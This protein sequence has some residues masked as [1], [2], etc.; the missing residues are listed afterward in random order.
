MQFDISKIEDCQA[1]A[2]A[3]ANSATVPLTIGLIGTLGAGKTQWTRFLALACGAD[4]QSIASPTFTLV[5]HY[6]GRVDVYHIDTFRVKTAAEFYDLGVDELFEEPAIV[7]VEWADRF[8]E[9][10]PPDRLDLRFELNGDSRSVEVLS[11]G[12]NSAQVV[13]LLEAAWRKRLQDAS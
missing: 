6:P 7:V 5:H 2:E 3:V 10:L 13:E 12:Q 8:S 4:S 9:C 11:G 1:F